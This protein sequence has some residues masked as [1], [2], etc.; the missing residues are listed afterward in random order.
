KFDEKEGPEYKF[1]LYNITNEIIA[2]SINHQNKKLK[3][4][5]HRASSGTWLIGESFKFAKISKTTYSWLWRNLITSSDY[6]YLISN[7][8]SSASQYFNYSLSGVMPEYDENGITN[9]EEI[10]KVE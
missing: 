5:E 8:W 1:D 2:S 9:Q 10:D 4:L 3:A 6:K 7:Y